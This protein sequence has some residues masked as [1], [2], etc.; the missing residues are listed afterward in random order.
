MAIFSRKKSKKDETTFD[1]KSKGTKETF[2]HSSRHALA[3]ELARQMAMQ[4]QSEVN[5]S[6]DSTPVDSRAVVKSNTQP[7]I[8]DMLQHID[9][10]FLLGIV[11]FFALSAVINVIVS[12][13]T[14]IV[15]L[16]VI[17][18]LFTPLT[19][20]IVQEMQVLQDILE[21]PKSQLKR[22]ESNS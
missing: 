18:V 3:D 9:R 17:S 14:S 19:E 22:F 8:I 2:D 4:L 16:A 5:K 10:R 20:Q 6:N 21:E 1:S 12:L 7:N 15:L 13:V 11:F